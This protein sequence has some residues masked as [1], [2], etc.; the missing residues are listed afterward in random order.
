MAQW[1]GQFSGN[2]Q[3]TAV[4]D[5]EKLLSHAASVFRDSAAATRPKKAKAVRALARRLHAARIRFLRAQIR[6]ASGPAVGEAKGA[7]VKNIAKLEEAL[8]VV[9]ADGI[10]GIL[11]EFSAGDARQT[12]T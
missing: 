10:D 12:A 1:L 11:R 3:R 9:Q 4:E 8:E 5:A 6:E 2:T 7:Y